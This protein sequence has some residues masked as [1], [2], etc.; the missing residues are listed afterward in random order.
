MTVSDFARWPLLTAV[1]AVSLRPRQG[2]THEAYGAESHEPE[3]NPVNDPA[4]CRGGHVSGSGVLSHGSFRRAGK[5]AIAA[6]AT[7]V[8]RRPAP[9]R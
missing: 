8:Q 3:G 9:S 6:L 1:L 2:D 5:H 7:K 4:R